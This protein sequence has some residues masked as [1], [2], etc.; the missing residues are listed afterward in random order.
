[1]KT[2]I[3]NE[4]H[5]LKQNSDGQKARWQPKD[6]SI[7]TV[8]NG[9]DSKICDVEYESDKLYSSDSVCGNGL[10]AQHFQNVML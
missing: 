9:L 1:V 8:A 7:L 4:I 3:L 6:D 10:M 5:F 2:S